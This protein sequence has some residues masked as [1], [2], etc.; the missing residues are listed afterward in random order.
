LLIVAGTATAHYQPND[1]EDD[2]D[3][4]ATHSAEFVIALD[5]LTGSTLWQSLSEDLEQH[6]DANGTAQTAAPLPV[7]A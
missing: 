5:A 3:D 2:D 1:N 7:V 4:E 6:H